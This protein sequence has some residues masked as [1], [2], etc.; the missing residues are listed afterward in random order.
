MKMVPAEDSVKEL[1][2]LANLYL[3]VQDIQW[4]VSFWAFNNPYRDCKVL[5]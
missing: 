5:K 4:A 3:L 1:H 2:A